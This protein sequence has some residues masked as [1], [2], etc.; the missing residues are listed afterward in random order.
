MMLAHSPS[1][2]GLFGLRGTILVRLVPRSPRGIGRRS[3]EESMKRVAIVG[4]T[5]L[6]RD[7]CSPHLARRSSSFFRAVFAPLAPFWVGSSTAGRSRAGSENRIREKKVETC[8]KS[9][10]QPFEAREGQ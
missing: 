3:P 8:V 5:G 9:S 2:F 6:L 7:S 1:R 4:F 10:S